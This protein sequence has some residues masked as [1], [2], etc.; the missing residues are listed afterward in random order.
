MVGNFGIMA[1][2]DVYFLIALYLESHGISDP[3]TIGWILSAYFAASVLSRPFIGW[4]VERLSFKPILITAS[5][6]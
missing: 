1:F 5:F 2:G 4:V 6:A 3:E